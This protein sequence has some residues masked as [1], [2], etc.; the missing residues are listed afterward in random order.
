M[1]IYIEREIQLYNY[2]RICA[3]LCKFS[4]HPS[5]VT[6]IGQAITT[7]KPW[8]GSRPVSMDM[9]SPTENRYFFKTPETRHLRVSINGDPE[10][11]RFI[12]DDSI[13]MDDDL[14]VALF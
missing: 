14:G 1:D 8:L 13:K 2:L 5:C 7:V 6:F 3:N 12:G 4:I 11:G 10:N 9:L